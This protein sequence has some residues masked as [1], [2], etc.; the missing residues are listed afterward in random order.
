MTVENDNSLDAF[1]AAIAAIAADEPPQVADALL[2]AL[3]ELSPLAPPAALR[4]QL[5]QKVAASPPTVPQQE[6]ITGITFAY[7][8]AGPWLPTPIPGVSMKFLDVD[9][10]SRRARTL[11]R[12]AAGAVYPPHRHEGD[13]ET[14]VIDGA[15]RID[16]KDMQVGDYCIARA[17]TVHG[18]LTSDAGATFVAFVCLDDAP[19]SAEVLRQA[20]ADD[21]RTRPG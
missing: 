6:P 9:T 5:L 20:R 19:V 14:L 13:E 16:G 21:P 18:A 10:Q 12:L 8:S 3:A 1:T 7:G 11:V 15:I 4:E 17:G 2:A